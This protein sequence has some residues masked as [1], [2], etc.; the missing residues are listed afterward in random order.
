MAILSTFGVDIGGY[1]LSVILAAIA[2][3]VA[4]YAV[5]FPVRLDAQ[6]PPILRP[7]I[8]FIGHLLGLLSHAFRYYGMTLYAAN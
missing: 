7:Q 8:P 4:T 6:E 3:P 5:W 1:S 2:L